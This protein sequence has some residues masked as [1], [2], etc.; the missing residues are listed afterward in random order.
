M[1]NRQ[2]TEKQWAKV[3]TAITQAVLIAWDGCHKIYLINDLDSAQPFLHDYPFCKSPTDY[4]DAIDTIEEWFNE[5]CSLRFIS[6]VH[7][8]NKKGHTNTVLVPQ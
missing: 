6:A 8:P 1:S 5:S 7:Q 3:T 2:P 4:E